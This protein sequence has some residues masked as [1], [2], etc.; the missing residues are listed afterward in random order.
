MKF[1]GAGQV[2]AV[3]REVSEATTGEKR[4]ET[5]FGVTSQKPGGASP[6][7]MSGV[8]RGQRRIEVA[9]HIPGWS[10]DEDRSRIR[11][12]HR[13]AKTILFRR[14]TIGLMQQRG[15]EVAGT[16]C[17]MARRPWRELDLLGMTGTTRPLTTAA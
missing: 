15:K 2:L 11:T 13:P 16:M 3:R 9:H 17:A 7:H 8:N 1:T 14:I 12:G 5:V 4:V 10:F 6:K